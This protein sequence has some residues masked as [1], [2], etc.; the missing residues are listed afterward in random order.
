MKKI[1]GNEL[2]KK[3]LNEAKEKLNNEKYKCIPKPSLVIIQVGDNQSSNLYSDN[4]KKACEK[5]GIR[6]I[7]YKYKEDVTTEKLARIIYRLSINPRV[8][9]ILIQLPLPN[10]IDKRVLID[11]L[12][13]IKDVDGFTCVQA[14]MLQLGIKNKYRLEP[15][16]A[17]GI[18]RLLESITTLEGKNITIIGRSNIIGKPVAQLLQE[19]NANITLCHS[20]TN[21]ADIEKNTCKSDIIILTTGQSEYFNSRFFTRYSY[22]DPTEKIIIDAGINI[23]NNGKLCGDLNIKDVNNIN[24]SNNISYIQVTDVVGSMAIAELID[25]ICIAYDVQ[26]DDI[27]NYD[28]MMRLIKD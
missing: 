25:N 2:A 22:T 8:T 5:V 1:N 17:K 28:Q 14:G 7:I 27:W 4:K 3:V 26:F 15:Y 11:E 20:K 23:D 9:G 19:K 13:P 16:I 12:D 21:I 18:V 10:H 6:C 24:C